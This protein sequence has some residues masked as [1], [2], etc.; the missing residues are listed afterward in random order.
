M[1]LG[2][3]SPTHCHTMEVRAKLLR[4]GLNKANPGLGLRRATASRRGSGSPLRRS[5]KPRRPLCRRRRRRRR[6]KHCPLCRRCHPC[7]VSL[8]R[9]RSWL[10]HQ[11]HQRRPSHLPPGRETQQRRRANSLEGLQAAE[12]AARRK[13]RRPAHTSHRAAAHTGCWA[14]AHT[15]Q[16]APRALAVEHLAVGTYHHLLERF[17]RSRLSRR[18]PAFRR[19]FPC[20]SLPVTCREA[21]CT[22]YI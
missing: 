19:P 14:A 7:R 1:L 18:T 17:R 21:W 10:R 9:R 20:P 13:R 16:R 15:R 11:Q 22:F 12:V 5:H 8:H 3:G 2:H 6:R 4:V